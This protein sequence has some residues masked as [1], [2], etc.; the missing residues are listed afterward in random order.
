MQV[1]LLQ[2]REDILALVHYQYHS[3]TASGPWQVCSCALSGPCN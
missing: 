2:H 3:D 1:S